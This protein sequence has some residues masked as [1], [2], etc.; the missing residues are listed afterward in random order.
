MGTIKIKALGP[1][2]K[3]IP[4]ETEVSFNETITAFELVEQHFGIPNNESRMS[5]VVNGTIQKGN[6]TIQ[7]GDSI[8]VL[9]MGGAG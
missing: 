9:K 5:F 6:Y 3:Q 4:K 1:L 7:D 8:T 2:T